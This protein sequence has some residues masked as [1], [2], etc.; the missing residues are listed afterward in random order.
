MTMRPCLDC[1]QPSESTRCPDCAAERNRVRGRGIPDRKPSSRD[2]GYDWQWTKLSARARRVQPFCSDC[3]R[4]DDLQADHSE[5]A[6][7][8]K[9]LGLPLR[10]QDIDVV[11]G[12]CNRARGRQRPS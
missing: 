2:R 6:W 12:P 11:C 1:G 3:G 5:Q 8:R 4:T 9:A 7:R 10:L